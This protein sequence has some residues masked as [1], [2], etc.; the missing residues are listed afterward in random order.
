M[1]LPEPYFSQFKKALYGKAHPSFAQIA[2]VDQDHSPKVRTVLFYDFELVGSL[3]FACSNATEKWSQLQ[4]NPKVCGLYLDPDN[5][6]QYRFEAHATLLEQDDELSQL[7][8]KKQRADLKEFQWQEYYRLQN[9]TGE[10][11]VEKIC[12]LHG[13]V[14]LEP[15]HWDIFRLGLTDFAEGQRVII[16]KQNDEWQVDDNASIM[17]P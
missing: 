3:A 13:A 12:P 1:L 7:M 11:D 2:T 8:W 16:D 4:A 9:S 14:T 15:Y 17:H 10:I 6:A 5:W